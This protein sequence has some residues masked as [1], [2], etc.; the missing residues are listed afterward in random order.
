[1][2][3]NL[4]NTHKLYRDYVQPSQ[5]QVTYH[6]K[7][8]QLAKAVVDRWDTPLWKDVPHTAEYINELRNHLKDKK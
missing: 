3:D 1:M 4:D 5:P 7:L 8:V 2:N 6:E